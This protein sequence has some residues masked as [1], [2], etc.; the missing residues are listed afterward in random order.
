MAKRAEDFKNDPMIVPIGVPPAGSFEDWLAGLERGEEPTVLSVSA[1][2]LVAE[3][4]AEA[5]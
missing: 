2:Q 1:A 5:E 3:G 4:R